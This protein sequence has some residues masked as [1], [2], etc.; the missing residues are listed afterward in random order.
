MVNFNYC[1]YLVFEEN[2]MIFNNKKGALRDLVLGSRLAT[3][4]KNFSGGLALAIFAGFGLLIN[5]IKNIF[6]PPQQTSPPL[7]VIIIIVAII[8]VLLKKKGR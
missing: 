3:I 5:I 4:I 8:L 6:S 7:W 2:K 1:F